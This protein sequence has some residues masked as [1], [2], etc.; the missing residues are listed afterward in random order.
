MTKTLSITKARDNL[1]GIVEKAKRLLNTYVITVNGNPEAV[2]MSH[3]EYESIMETLDI[4]SDP[5]AL[6]DLKQSEK[7]IRQGKYVSLE[8]LKKDLGLA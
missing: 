2:V 8:D 7:E 5:K 3:R 4:L 6:S 1:T